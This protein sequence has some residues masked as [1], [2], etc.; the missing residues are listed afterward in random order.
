MNR[1]FSTLAFLAIGLML[2][3]MTLGLCLRL[4]DVRNPQDLTAQHWATVH[5]LAGILAA[6]FVVFVH[7]LVVTY[8]VGT[9][10]WCR[11]VVETYQLSP[12]LLQRGNR[13][14]RRT[15]PYAVTSMLGVVILA[16]LGGAADPAAAMQL[17][18]LD[19]NLGGASFD[20]TYTELHFAGALLI[21]S[22]IAYAM[23]IEW[24][25]IQANAE[26]INT[27]LA[28]VKRIR[29]EKGL[30]EPESEQ[31]AAASDQPSPAGSRQP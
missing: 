14:K 11:E 20:V 6:L 15:F 23:R 25:Q 27:I 22:Y 12:E 9:S 31:A 8:F 7:S 4:G 16:A 1:I 29:I 5:R 13:I 3:V 30:D 21:I 18:P 19:V 26:V 2:A 10:R 17:K 24:H 28:E